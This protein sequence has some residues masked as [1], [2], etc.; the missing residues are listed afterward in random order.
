EEARL[1]NSLRLDEPWDSPHNIEVAK[2]I[3]SVY[4]CPTRIPPDDHPE[5]RTSYVAVLGDRTMWPPSAKPTQLDDVQDGPEQTILLIEAYSDL[6]WIAPRDLSLDEGL[7]HL[8]AHQ[9]I[10]IGGPY[11]HGYFFDYHPG[12]HVLLTNGSVI[13]SGAGV[14][15]H[16]WSQ[17]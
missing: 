17:L 8:T 13:H 5:D 12:P 4:V 15:R 14:S 2:K 11:D 9:H 3:P 1:Y 7:G 10:H 6:P 16:T